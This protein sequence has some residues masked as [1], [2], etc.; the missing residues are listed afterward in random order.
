[1]RWRVRDVVPQKLEKR[2]VVG[3]GYN[4]NVGEKEKFSSLRRWSNDHGVRGQSRTVVSVISNLPTQVTL[5]LISSLPSSL[6][7]RN[8]FRII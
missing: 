4:C 1:M 7:K 8:F 3:N 2:V 5:S 6:S